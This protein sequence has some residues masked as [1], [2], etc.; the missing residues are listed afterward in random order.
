MS[1]PQTLPPPVG[2]R[3]VDVVS[4][5]SQ[6]AYGN[7]GNNIAVP[8]LL[9]LGL[10]VAPVPTVVFGNTPHYPTM[11]GGPLP[12]DWFKG[13]LDDLE[14]REAATRAKR[15]LVGYLGSPEQ[16]IALAEWLRRMREVN[17]ALRV[18]IDPVIGDHDYGI[19]TDPALLPVW[20]DH[21]MPLAEGLC[22]NHFEVGH[23]A[24]RSPRTLEDCL[25][26][27]EALLGDATRWVVVTSAAPELCPPGR[28]QLAIVG[29]GVRE[30]REH[31]LVPHPV[32]GVG[33]MFAAMIA[34]RLE[35]GAD[36]LDAVDRTC[37]DVVEVLQH[38]QAQGW[39]ELGLPRHIARRLG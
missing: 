17:P 1:R 34:G 29:D 28:I 6:V 8:V 12:L 13:L 23:L 7:V 25:D 22:P 11:H 4:V 31:P 33:D 38:V 24:G 30:V 2:E 19:Y 10:Q 26:A 14:A 27:A 9:A 37:A 39:Q 18:Q 5:Q 16:G 20:R 35:N 15:V 21:L 32:K 36:L 3:I